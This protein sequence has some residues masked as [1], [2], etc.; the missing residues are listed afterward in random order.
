MG[1][2]ATQFVRTFQ[3]SAT[4]GEVTGGL[5]T[6][7]SSVLSTSRGRTVHKTRIAH[8]RSH[9]APLR[10][11]L[12]GGF[13]LNYRGGSVSVPLGVRRLLVF[14]ALQARPVIRAYVAG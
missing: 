10:L 5:E 8:I 6:N 1:R 7:G 2:D 11:D 9:T 14:L 3:G 4:E 12:L 13:E